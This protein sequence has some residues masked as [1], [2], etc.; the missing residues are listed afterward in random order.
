M[1]CGDIKKM[2]LRRRC[3]GV[4]SRPKGLDVVRFLYSAFLISTLLVSPAYASGL[5]VT[6]EGVRGNKGKIVI[7]VYDQKEAFEHLS[8][9]MTAAFV[10]VPA[11]EGR[12]YCNLPQLNDGP[13][14]VILFHDENSDKSLNTDGVRLKEGVGVSGAPNREDRPTFLEA[15]IASS[16]VSIRVHYDK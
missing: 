13:Y 7:A 6:A 9:S 15:S 12:V 2:K 14:A 1:S 4:A 3:N 10:E 11:K 16:T 5:H 8:R